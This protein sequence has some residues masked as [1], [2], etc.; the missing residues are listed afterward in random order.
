MSVAQACSTRSMA[1]D[2]DD[3]SYRGKLLLAPMVRVNSL[4]FRTLCGVYGADMLYSEEI[5]ARSLVACR[6]TENAALGTVDFVA[7]ADSRVV[8]RTRPKER[9]VLQL[10]TACAAEALQAAM[11]AASDVRA[12]DLNMGCPV[13]F[14][15]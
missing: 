4:A 7:P 5:V 3:W 11:C 8:F 10:G 9:V 2:E 14:S 6:R 15:L 1:S 12:V 13:K